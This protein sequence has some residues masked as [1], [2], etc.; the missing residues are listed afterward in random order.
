MLILCGSL[1]LAAVLAMVAVQPACSPAQC[2]QS[3]IDPNTPSPA[4]ECAAG[5]LCYQGQCIRACSAGQ[6]RAE[7]CG[8]DGDCSGSRP[9]CIDGFCSSCDDAEY[10]VPTLN[11]CQLTTEID[12]TELE[13][14][15]MPPPGAPKPPA[16]LSEGWIDGGLRL[17]KDAG[18]EVPIDVVVTHAGL[19]DIAQLEDYTG[20][21]P[22]L[23]SSKINVTMLRVD[24]V[25]EPGL[26]WRVDPWDDTGDYYEPATEITLEEVLGEECALLQLTTYTSSAGLEPTNFGD[27]FIDSPTEFPNSIAQRIEIYW[28]DLLGDY[29]V[30]DTPADLLRYSVLAPSTPH[31]LDVSSAGSGL[32]SGSWPNPPADNGEHVPFALVPSQD[33]ITMLASGVQVSIASPGDLVVRWDRIAA[34]SVPGENVVLR[35]RGDR[36]EVNCQIAEGNIDGSIIVK[37]GL[38][39]S[40]IMREGVAAG[41]NLPLYFERAYARRLE[42]PPATT[43]IIDIAVRIRHTFIG[44]I[45]FVP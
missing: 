34:G 6:E 39:R 20:G 3:L 14:P 4:L 36:H 26:I 37:A 9:N 1:G 44:T 40:F 24:T 17:E 18:E 41:T 28:D 30:P 38:L 32:T 42:V 12:L 33:T 25:P 10:C 29:D 45:R 13:P 23:Q 7:E 31:F 15:P 8:G 11:I 16:P 35:F 2:T 27:I 22:P 21:T 5:L 19:I 43:E